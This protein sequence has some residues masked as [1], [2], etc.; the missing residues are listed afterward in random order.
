MV[1]GGGSVSLISRLFS[2]NVGRNRVNIVVCTHNDSDHA[3]GI[4]GLLKSEICCKE[5]WLP[6]SWYQRLNDLLQRPS[7]FLSELNL[8][9]TESQSNG[10]TGTSGFL[11]FDDFLDPI[12]KRLQTQNNDANNIELKMETLESDARQNV[13]GLYNSFEA[14]F[15]SF[16][17]CLDTLGPTVTPGT[18][19]LKSAAR[20]AFR[21]GNIYLNA[22]KKKAHIRWFEYDADQPACGGEKNFLIP[23]NSRETSTW[24]NRKMSAIEYVALTAINTESLVFYS[25][26]TDNCLGTL[27]TSDSNL[28]FKQSIDWHDG[29]IVTAPHHGSESNYESYQRFAKEADSKIEVNWVRSDGNFK[30]RPGTSYLALTG[31]RFCTLC[32]NCGKPKQSVNLTLCGGKWVP[33][34]TRKCCCK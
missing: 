30:R 33:V 6:A 27:F 29:M 13:C 22:I 3:K 14:H 12:Y 11:K 31:P 26:R 28:E 5:L 1:D 25:P 8:N 17:A 15:S 19:H 18:F 4:L 32:R 23:V 21:M 16:L 7:E 10:K 34:G 9:V 2:N 20:A 24:R